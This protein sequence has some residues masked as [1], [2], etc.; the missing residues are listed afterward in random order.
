VAAGRFREDLYYRLKIISLPVLPLRDRR[1]DI[2]PLARHFLEIYGDKIKARQLDLSPSAEEALFAYA[3]PGNI[4]ELEN[5]IHRATL[6]ARDG[7]ILAEDLALPTTAPQPF[8]PPAPRPHCI[9]NRRLPHRL[10]HRQASMSRISR[11]IIC[12]IAPPPACSRTD[13]PIF[14]NAPF[15]TWSTKR[16]LGTTTTRSRLLRLS[17]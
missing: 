3:W 14:W 7:T 5:A 10:L 15:R 4:R 16:W 17:A 6:T 2:L 9:P 13:S 12:S 11:S 1:A 8:P